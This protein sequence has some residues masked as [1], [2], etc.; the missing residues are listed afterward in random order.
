[1]TDDDRHVTK[2]KSYMFKTDNQLGPIVEHT[3][4]CS[5]LRAR[6]DGAGLRGNRDMYTCG[7]N[8]ARETFLFPWRSATA[9]LISCTL[10]QNK[11][12]TV[13]GEKERLSVYLILWSDYRKI[14]MLQ[15]DTL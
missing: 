5:V 3:E 2:F 12:F 10:I 1:M 8:Y 4:L 7:W 9:L 11:K 13:W 14:A 15:I 6:L